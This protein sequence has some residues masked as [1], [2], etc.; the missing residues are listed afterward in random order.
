MEETNGWL[1]F[2]VADV[3]VIIFYYLIAGA[4]SRMLNEQA[5]DKDELTDI[6][7]MDKKELWPSMKNNNL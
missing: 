6:F 4:L 7:L 1:Y 2:P 5:I 3:G